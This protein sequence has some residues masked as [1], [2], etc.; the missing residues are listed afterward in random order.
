MNAGSTSVVEWMRIIRSEFL[1]FPE[2]R[3]TKAQV[4]RLWSLDALTCEVLLAA[5]IDVQFLKR[6]ASGSYARADAGC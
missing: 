3:L 4:Q 1:E 5:L 2:M 6:T